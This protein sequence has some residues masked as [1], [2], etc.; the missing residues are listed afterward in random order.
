MVLACG[1][2]TARPP[3]R[4]RRVATQCQNGMDGRAL[5]TRGLRGERGAMRIW[6]ARPE[7]GAARTAARLTALGHRPII[8]PVLAVAPTGQRLPESRFEGLILTSANAVR[9]LSAEE[10]GR[11]RTVP[12]FAVG[13][14]TGEL[15]KRSGLA[16]VRVAQGD[17]EGLTRLVA[18]SLPARSRLLHAAGTDRKSEPEASLRHAG[19]R[20]HMCET[21]TTRIAALL[22]ESLTDALEAGEIDAVLHYSRRSASAAHDLATA[23]GRSG[24]FRALT[25]YCLSADVA[26]P[27]VSAGV[28][29]HFVPDRPSE[30]ALLAGL[31]EIGPAGI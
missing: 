11:F 21:Y 30:D 5:R 23:H 24:A 25:H 6:V 20:L 16:D 26:A 4:Q 7:P 27:L 13:A 8:A 17:A 31:A 29:V 19:F 28:T 14:R 22:P 15:A 3:V 2:L 10:I 18:A 12:A 9:C 1:T